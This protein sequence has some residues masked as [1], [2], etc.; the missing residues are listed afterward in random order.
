MLE[1]LRLHQKSGSAHDDFYLP[2]RYR[3]ENIE[4]FIF[5][6]LRLLLSPLLLLLLLLLLI[7]VG[8]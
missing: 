3:K 5:F 6:F 2:A 7:V 8:V 1:S 4:E